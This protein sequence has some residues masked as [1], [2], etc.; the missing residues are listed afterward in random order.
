MRSTR[1][2]TQVPFTQKLVLNQ[3]LLSKFNVTSSKEIAERLKREDSEGMDENNV[4]HFHHILTAQF[5]DLEKLSKRLLLEYDQNIVRHTLH[6]NERRITNGDPP[7][8]WKYFQY[9]GLL[10]CEIY[11][12][13]YFEDSES[14]L[15]E[16]AI[17]ERDYNRKTPESDQMTLFDENEE[18][19]SQLNKIAFWM[20]TGSGKTLIMHV[21][22]RQYRHYLTKHGKHEE[23]DHILLLTPNE[24]L[25]QQHLEE[26]SKANIDAEIFDKNTS[27]L[28]NR[29]PIEVL[30]VT[31]LGEEMGDKTIAVEALEG[32]NLV[33]V[34][35]GHRG[36]SSGKT[37]TW[38][39]LRDALCEKGFSFEYSATFGQAI[40]H[41]R[42]LTETYAKSTLFDYSY[43]YFYG[44]GFGKDYRIFNIDHRTQESQLELY[45]VACLLS[46]FQQQHLYQTN[47]TEFQLFNFEQPLL[48]FVGGSVVKSLSIKD[49][50]DIVS[51]L[52]FLD[53]YVTDRSGSI[54]RIGEV[55][56]DGIKTSI[57]I[58]LLERQ[59]KHLNESGLT[60]NQIFDASLAM[61]FNAPAGGRLHVENLRG[62]DGEVALRLGAANEPFG[63]INVGRPDQLVKRCAEHDLNTGESEFS[64]SLFREIN[65]EESKINLLIGSRKFTEGWSSWRV[66]TMGLMNVGKSEGAQIIQLF[67]RGVRLKGYNS[68]LKRS[69]AGLPDGIKPPRHI[70]VLETL[71][72]F[73]IRAD[74]MA[75]FRD[76]LSE[77]GLPTEN[78]L[79]EFS[80]PTVKNFGKQQLKT[81]RLQESINGFQTDF[82]DAFRQL[83]PIPTLNPPTLAGDSTAEY[84]YKN[85][86]V[87]NW[88]PKIEAM[89]SSGIEDEQR[90]GHLNEAKFSAHHIAFLNLDRLYFEL[91]RFK[92][93]RGWFN[94]NISAD[95][96]KQILANEDWYILQIPKSELRADSYENVRIWEEIALSMLRKYT[97]RYFT[98]CK[99][100]WEGPH[101]EYRALDCD[102]TNFF[103]EYR[104]VLDES[105]EDVVGKLEELQELIQNGD[106]KP[107]MCDG[108]QE[109][110]FSQHLYRPLFYHDGAQV[111]ISP[112]PLNQG[113]RQFVDDLRAYYE[114]NSDVLGTSELYLLRNLSR[115][116]GVGFF[117]A[118]NFHPDF[119]LWLL[120]GNH[121]T[122]MFVDPKGLRQMG[123]NDPK[124]LFYETIK[125]IEK[126]LGDSE[127]NLE[128]YIISNTTSIE[129]QRLWGVSKQDM[130]NRHILFQ[131]EDKNTYIQSMLL[132]EADIN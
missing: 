66:S 62:V 131:K 15:K 86:V 96:L 30:E 41:D 99:Q 127:V 84:F 90:V 23:L 81:I 39:R 100:T 45:L 56:R 83:G 93:E 31:R 13:R 44:D 111:Q 106:L 29:K 43:R 36:A 82:G 49:A 7:I 4:H 74:Y 117:E 8:T 3:W 122:I 113:E 63:V 25:S 27:V 98:Y 50:T 17:W 121:Q 9:L 26:F 97:E 1:R 76:F 114:K 12:D 53:R 32:N 58:N 14:L 52:L 33:L 71:G 103:D 88:Y 108:I 73:G 47:K 35:E 112:V 129:M 105:K 51:I 61:I 94:L 64:A 2:Q 10:F 6:L 118:N 28:F 48:V 119:I 38:I 42:D 20:A 19:W 57:G 85:P 128:S 46:F 77:E 69:S 95:A 34:D 68:S 130:V 11:L 65:A 75:Q 70:R 124:I 16:L 87:I 109:V 21:N 107:W 24:G 80:L 125:D 115:G 72:I 110:Q 79:I 91:E 59:F 116:R 102:D 67:G 89:E 92:T 104:I 132:G 78:E 120:K 5:H 60:S 37:G 54:K 22:S 55:L 101:L 18:A 126:R 40:K 123:Y